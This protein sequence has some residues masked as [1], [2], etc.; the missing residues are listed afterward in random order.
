MR[1][2][3]KILWEHFLLL[4]IAGMF[5]GF[6]LTNKFWMAI[7]PPWGYVTWPVTAHILYLWAGPRW[8]A[9]FPR[10]TKSM[11]REKISELNRL[12]AGKNEVI[13]GYIK[14]TVHL[15]EEVRRLKKEIGT[16]E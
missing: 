2:L 14:T 11:L 15:R 12:V 10:V 16:G 13:M 6:I 7:L 8:N 1:S 5:L 9:R 3:R 4:V